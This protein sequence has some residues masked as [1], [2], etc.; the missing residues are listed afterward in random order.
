MLNNYYSKNLKFIV[1]QKRFLPK[2]I[3]AISL[4][5]FLYSCTKLD[6]TVQGA[7]LLTVD[8][9]NTKADTLEV[10]T[11]QGTFAAG[12]GVNY[13]S[14]IISKGDNHLLGNIDVPNFG[15]TDARIYVQ[16]KPPFFPYYFGNAGDIVKF[17]PDAGLDS[18]FLLLSFRS[19]WGDS[20]ASAIPQNIEVRAVTDPLFKNKPDSLF[21]LRYLP[22]TNPNPVI[23][24]ALLTPKTVQQYSYFY[25]TGKKLDSVTNV[26]RIRLNNLMFGNPLFTQDSSANPLVMNNAFYLDSLYRKLYN[27]LEIKSTTTGNSLYSFNLIDG[28]TRLE[29][30][31]HKKNTGTTPA[32]LDTLTAAFFMEPSINLLSGIKAPSSTAN[33]VKRDYTVGS[34]AIVNGLTTTNAYLQAAPG[35]F[36]NV[37]IPGLT[38]MRNKMHRIVHRAY[39]QI[40]QNDGTALPSKFAPPAFIYADLKDSITPNRFKPVY[41]DLSASSSYNPDATFLNPLYHPFPSANL[42]PGNFGGVALNRVDGGIP[43]TRYEI[44]VTRYVQ[45]I[46]SNN[47]YNYDFRVFAPYNYFYN[48]YLGNQYVI[49]FYNQLANG[50]VRVGGGTFPANIVPH[51]MKMIIIY[52]DVK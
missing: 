28:K 24:T 16:F 8:N 43:F 36:V 31:Y 21:G 25:R 6:T 38:G 49:P 33:Y 11:T 4:I 15:K 9:I 20:S 39:L 19:L 52:S 47:F 50:A 2:A 45:H 13:D 42:E 27:G 5:S 22:N 14:T 10:I 51:R 35:T 34:N 23:G 44:N 37:S 40:D 17:N 12:S 32:V 1:L 18:V 48:Q 46:I 26:L 29:F 30:H 41:F 3:V 7:D